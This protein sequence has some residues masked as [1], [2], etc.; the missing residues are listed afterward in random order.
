MTDT[1]ISNPLPL[2]S[3]PGAITPATVLTGPLIPAIERIRLFSDSQWEE[4]VLEWGDSLRQTYSR[5]DRCGGAGD[6][7][8]DIIAIVNDHESLWDNYQCKH[9]GAPL[10]P[11][12]IWIEIGKLVYYT[13]AGVFTVP[14]RYYFVAP[15]GI[16]TK[17][18]NLLKRPVELRA[19]LID[20][21]DHYCRNDIT[22]TAAITLTRPLRAYV[23]TFDFSIFDSVPP[24]RLIDQH[25]T[26]RWY[27]ARFGGGLPPRPLADTPPAEPAPQEAVY[28]RQLFNAYAD[29]LKQP[30]AVIND[31]AAHTD[32]R[33]H[34]G[35]SRIE[36]FSAESLRSFSRDT[37][38]PGEFEKLQDEIHSGV[39][40]QV[41]ADHDD[42]YR[43]VVA[44]VATA[45]ALQLTDHPLISCLST[46][47]R[48]GVCHQLANDNRVRWT[49]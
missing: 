37:L 30:V 25:A 43:R 36:F 17:L 26:T 6:R 14:R 38:P 46:R 35:D 49:K 13:Q 39:K 11:S 45:R 8:R 33:E 3:H 18:S 47:D 5:V 32:L 29:R 24:L 23:D 9:Y 4:F 16:G 1:P 28:V 2:P 20:N 40:D 44:V 27:V 48:G 34:F 19:G 7:G 10:A 15:L 41:R 42:G 12:D 31:I 22:T 21:W